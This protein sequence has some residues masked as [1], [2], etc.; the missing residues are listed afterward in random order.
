MKI[1]A[2]LSLYH[3]ERISAGVSY[4]LFEQT[5]DLFAL[6]DAIRQESKAIRVWRQLVDAAG[7]VYTSNLVMGVRYSELLANPNRKDVRRSDMSGHWKD[8][9][10]W[11]E[12]D[13]KQLKQMRESIV[14]KTGEKGLLIS[15]VPIRSMRPGKELIIRASVYAASDIE[16]V[17]CVYKTGNGAYQYAAMKSGDH[18]RYSTRIPA[19]EE[20]DKLNYY[21]LAEASNGTREQTDPVTLIISEDRKPPVISHKGIAKSRPGKSLLVT[22][23]VNDAYGIKWVRLRYRHLTQFEDYETLDMHFDDNTGNYSATIPG[24]YII[25]QWDL[26]YFIEAM[27]ERGN[28]IM[29]PN[30]EKET[31]YFIVNLHAAD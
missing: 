14:P 16:S 26:I 22:A 12:S 6:D 17:Q 11:M 20:G 21:L 18:G 27:D 3:G 23:K 19:K 25:P 10:P 30:F 28:G 31:P 4:Q 5:Q 24:E 13:L 15:H 2:Y 29:F 7:D 1:L 8:E 9:L